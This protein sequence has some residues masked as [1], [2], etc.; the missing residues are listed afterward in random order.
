MSAVQYIRIRSIDI[1][2]WLAL[3]ISLVRIFT[4][5]ISWGSVLL[6]FLLFTWALYKSPR[7][8]LTYLDIVVSIVLLYE[9][10]L[11]FTSVNPYPGYTY[12]MMS[13]YLWAFYFICRLCIR[14]ISQLRRVLFFLSIV[15]FCISLVAIISFVQFRAKVLNAG[16]SS[17]YEFR[18]LLTPGKYD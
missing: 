11:P 5:Y 6:M 12:A 3:L 18:F 15:I 8:K 7:F 2:L 17:L 4:C 1:I 14:S 13:F 9:L 16:F 10:I